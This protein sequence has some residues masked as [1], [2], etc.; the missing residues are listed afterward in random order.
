MNCFGFVPK[1]IGIYQVRTNKKRRVS[2]YEDIA[3][4]DGKHNVKLAK[5]DRKDVILL[6]EFVW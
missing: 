3:V 4:P 1:R 5:Q 2:R 6:I